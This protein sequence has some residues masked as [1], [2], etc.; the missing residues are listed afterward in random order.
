MQ[1]ILYVL[2]WKLNWSEKITQLQDTLLEFDI[3]KLQPKGV[4]NHKLLRDIYEA[5]REKQEREREREKEQG[6]KVQSRK[7]YRLWP[8][9]MEII[10]QTR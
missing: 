6:E 8:L 9:D 1:N 2:F 10:L 4:N 7:P 5:D 3:K